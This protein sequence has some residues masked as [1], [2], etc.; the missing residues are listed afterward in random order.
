MVDGRNPMTEMTVG[1]LSPQTQLVGSSL[2]YGNRHWS[3]FGM[4]APCR[5]PEQLELRTHDHLK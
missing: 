5:S 2:I 3:A 4:G 1:S